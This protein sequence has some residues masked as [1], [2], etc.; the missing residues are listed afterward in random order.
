M[1]LVNQ[2][3]A[4]PVPDAAVCAAGGVASGTSLITEPMP[5]ELKPLVPGKVAEIPGLTP[6]SV[7]NGPLLPL[8]NVQRE[9]PTTLPPLPPQFGSVEKK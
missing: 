2:R 9:A 8:D 4:L 5:T 1:L 7:P 6:L 3:P